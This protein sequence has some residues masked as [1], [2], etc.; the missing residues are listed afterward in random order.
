MGD[1]LRTCSSLRW[2]GISRRDYVF[3]VSIEGFFQMDICFCKFVSLLIALMFGS[4]MVCA[5]AFG[6][7]GR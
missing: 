7:F 4:L 1:F 2:A 5:W 6:F 3:I